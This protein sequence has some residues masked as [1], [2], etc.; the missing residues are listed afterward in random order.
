MEGTGRED[1]KR[2]I[3]SLMVLT[4]TGPVWTW[5]ILLNA[6]ALCDLSKCSPTVVSKILSVLICPEVLFFSR[7]YI[8]EAVVVSKGKD[9][10]SKVNCKIPYLSSRNLK[11]A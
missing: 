8:T 7:A 3:T 1:A 5:L 6:T 10:P 4:E 2:T 9:K 11:Q